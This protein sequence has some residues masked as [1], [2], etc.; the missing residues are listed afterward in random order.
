MV[1]ERVSTLD[2]NYNGHSLRDKTRAKKKK[3]T[4]VSPILAPILRLPFPL[5]PFFFNPPLRTK[6]TSGER[7]QMFLRVAT[8]IFPL[9]GGQ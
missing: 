5:L 4:P 2:L 3:R 9:I 8:R 1:D 6:R 7:I